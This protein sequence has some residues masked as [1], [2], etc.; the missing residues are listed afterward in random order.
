MPKK[1][2]NVIDLTKLPYITFG[3]GVVRGNPKVC[4]ACG[5]PIKPGEAWRKDVSAYDAKYGRYSTIRHA[6][7]KGASG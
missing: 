5:K 7:C 1:L 3:R 4:I 6:N 2:C